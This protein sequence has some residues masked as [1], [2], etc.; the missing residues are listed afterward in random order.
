[1]GVNEGD[2]QVGID[3]DMILEK[4]YVG[5]KYKATT[6]YFKK[7]QNA[8]RPSEHPQ[9]KT[10]LLLIRPVLPALYGVYISLSL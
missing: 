5:C 7:K 9:V 2:S 3:V 6:W 1:M 10:N 4:Y 8:P